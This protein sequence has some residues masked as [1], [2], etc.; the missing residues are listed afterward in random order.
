V[1]LVFNFFWTLAT[2]NLTAPRQAREL[3]KK[4]FPTRSYSCVELRQQAR[5]FQGQN[6]FAHERI[7]SRMSQNNHAP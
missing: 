6:G 1:E 3:G 7:A 5:L 4:I 2:A